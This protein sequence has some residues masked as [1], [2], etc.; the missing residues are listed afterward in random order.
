MENLKSYSDIIKGLLNEYK[1]AAPHLETHIVTDNIHH[2]Y[3][4]LR[5]GWVD[6]D[7]LSMRIIL[8]FQIKKDGKVWLMSNWTEDD[9]AEEL[10][11]RGIAKS[12]IVL[13]LLPE[14]TRVHT[15][16]AVA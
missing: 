8:Y 13:G 5:M 10:V 16:Y 14:Y 3:Q 12:D 2:H 11:K 15:G 9:V 7:T 4:V 6:K 1:Q